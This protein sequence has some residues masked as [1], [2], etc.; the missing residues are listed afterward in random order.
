MVVEQS[1]RCNF[2]FETFFMSII[3]IKSVVIFVVIVRNLFSL[4]LYYLQHCTVLFK[5]LL[6]LHLFTDLKFLRKAT[7][8]L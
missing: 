2:H 5:N 4:L 6:V 8:K 3:Q 7:I 1:F